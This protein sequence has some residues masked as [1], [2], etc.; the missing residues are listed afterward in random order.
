MGRKLNYKTPKELQKKIESYFKDCDKKKKRYTVPGLA[1]FLGFEN[2]HS[3]SNYGKREKF[4]AT[5]KSAM[6]RVETQRNEQ[7]LDEGNAAGKIFDLKN[8]FGWKDKTEI[9]HSGEIKTNWV[10]YGDTGPDN[11]GAGKGV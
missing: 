3:V 4:C 5:I 8:N 2:R 7:L 6:L 1:L 11:T 9:E 10:N